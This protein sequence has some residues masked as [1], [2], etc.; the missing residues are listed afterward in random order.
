MP[1]GA[2]RSSGHTVIFPRSATRQ[3]CP[4]ASDRTSASEP[5][6]P[7]A[8]HCGDMARPCASSGRVRRWTG[9]RWGPWTR[10]E[11]DAATSRSEGRGTVPIRSTTPPAV[12]AGG[13]AASSSSASSAAAGI[14]P[15]G[16]TGA[17][18]G[19]GAPHERSRLDAA[20]QR[21]DGPGHA[22]RRLLDPDARE[23]PRDQ[24]NQRAARHDEPHDR[25]QEGPQQQ[26]EQEPLAQQQAQG[27][28][29]DAPPP[30]LSPTALGPQGKAA[31]G[32]GDGGDGAGVGE[33]QV[34]PPGGEDESQRHSFELNLR[35]GGTLRLH[36]NYLTE[37]TRAELAQTMDDCSQKVPTTVP[38]RMPALYSTHT[39]INAS[40]GSLCNPL[41]LFLCRACSASTVSASSTSRACTAS[42]GKRRAAGTAT[43]A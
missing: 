7:G 12:G 3:Q 30:P 9:K 17:R 42:W 10:L 27:Q 25:P 8:L 39:P 28:A 4:P 15:T 22:Q 33:A 14:T 35:R 29:S 16:A 13:S 6:C 26:P 32:V 19:D 43:M 40:I 1:G 24:Q 38:T 20:E 18:P 34:L 23:P 21:G 37:S 41:L 31:V 5:L 11:I 2:E 36:K